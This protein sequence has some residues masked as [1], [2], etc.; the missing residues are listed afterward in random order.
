MMTTMVETCSD[1]LLKNSFPLFPIMDES[2]PIVNTCFIS[3][4]T[5][6][7]HLLL[8]LPCDLE[9]IG[10]H[11]NNLLTSVSYE[12]LCASKCYGLFRW[13]VCNEFAVI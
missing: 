8:R 9:V 4:N 3:F 12:I 5:S 6:S 11:L 2:S 1:E 10:F 7:S 13:W